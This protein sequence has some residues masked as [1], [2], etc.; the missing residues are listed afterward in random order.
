MG[1]GTS[2]TLDQWAT[3]M[4]ADPL[5]T[6]LTRRL[7]WRFTSAGISL[8]ALPAAAGMLDVQG[9]RVQLP[10]DSTAQ[11]WH[12]AD[13]PELQEVWRR[14]ASEIGLDQPVERVCREVTLAES[15]YMSVAAGSQVCQRPFRGF[16]MR[17]DWQVPY[18]G[19]FF[20]VPE[21]TKQVPRDGPL[22]VLELERP[23]E[24][25]DVVGVRGL[26]F[27]SVLG[28]DLDARTLPPPLVSEAA[29]DVLGAVAAAT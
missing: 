9:N 27:R 29:R 11:L 1:D 14:R 19:R 25:G 6:A 21:A 18:L 13:A 23:R 26:G 15:P 2:W 5:R 12:P 3:R 17:R 16:L 8:L 24:H 22:A 10:R 28:D 20:E 4:F 7:L